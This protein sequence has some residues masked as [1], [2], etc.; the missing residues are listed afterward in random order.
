MLLEVI[1][2]ALGVFPAL[3]GQT[4]LEADALLLQV[5]IKAHYFLLVT[6]SKSSNF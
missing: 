4:E 3:C 2:E 1:F 5:Q 6:L